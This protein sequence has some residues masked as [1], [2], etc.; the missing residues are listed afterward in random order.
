MTS[1]KPVTFPLKGNPHSL[2]AQR[3]VELCPKRTYSLFRITSPQGFF[4]L[5]CQG[6][7][8][9]N[10]IPTEEGTHAEKS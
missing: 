5:N 4:H 7:K 1:K 3:S 2:K 10:F 8:A 9:S 6:I